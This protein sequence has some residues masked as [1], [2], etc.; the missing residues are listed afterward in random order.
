E[1]TVMLAMGDSTK[2]GRVI[3]AKNS[4]KIG[5]ADM[6]GPGFYQ[7]KEINVILALRPDDGPAVIGVSAAG[8]TGLK[9][10]L[11]SVG[12]AS[13]CNLSRTVELDEGAASTTAMRAL[14]R[15]QLVRDGL[16]CST[17]MEAALKISAHLARNP[18]S[19][20]GNLQY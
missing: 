14:D 18:M 12:V 8:S 5:R 4:D 2:S 9:M 20:P 19:T 3:F 7:N 11:N 10:G 1:C 17:A 15:V 16:D 6:V 13:G